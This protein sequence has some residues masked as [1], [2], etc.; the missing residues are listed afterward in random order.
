MF[1]CIQGHPF[2]TVCMQPKRSRDKVECLVCHLGAQPPR[3]VCSANTTTITSTVFCLL[4]H[5]QAGFGDFQVSQW[6]GRRADAYATHL[7]EAI[8]RPNLSVVTGARA[9]QL[10]TESS[11]S[12]TRAVGVEYAVGG[13]SGSRQS[14]AE[15]SSSSPCSAPLCCAG[16]QHEVVCQPQHTVCVALDPLVPCA[17]TQARLAHHHSL[18]VLCVC[19]EGN[20]HGRTGTQVLARQSQQPTVPCVLCPVCLLLL[21]LSWRPAASCCC[22]AALLP[23]PSC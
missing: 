1:V 12:G 15:C 6:K 22:A 11:S 7:K 23:T 5:V 3:R 20:I 13:P 16:I 14:G 18:P 17:G 2:T 19:G 21:Q 10:A 8:G 9:T 4:V